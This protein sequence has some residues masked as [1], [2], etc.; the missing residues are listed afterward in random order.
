VSVHWR[1]IPQV[2]PFVLALPDLQG[3]GVADYPVSSF[4]FDWGKMTLTHGLQS[5]GLR[6][7]LIGR[8]LGD[9][10]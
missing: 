5:H 1:P 7:V 6:F 3:D 2:V 9:R 8:F 10:T 4:G